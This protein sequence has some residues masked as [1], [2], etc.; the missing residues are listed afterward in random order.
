MILYRAFGNV[1][2]AE[3]QNLEEPELKALKW[4]EACHMNVSDPCETVKFDEL[5]QLIV[6]CSRNAE[7]AEQQIQEQETV[8]KA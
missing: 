1:S 3:E 7:A 2:K 6:L 4:A 5:L 8:Q